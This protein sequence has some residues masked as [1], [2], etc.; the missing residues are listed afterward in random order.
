MAAPVY[1]LTIDWDNNTIVT[2][3]SAEDVTADVLNQGRWTYGYGRDQNR[4]LSPS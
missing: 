3:G 4:Q 2:G 1:T